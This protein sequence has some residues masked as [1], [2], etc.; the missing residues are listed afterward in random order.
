MTSESAHERSLRSQPPRIQ[1]GDGLTALHW[2]DREAY[3]VVAVSESR[4]T[5]KVQ[6]DKAIRTDDRGRSQHQTYRYEPQPDAKIISL[7]WS[8][9]QHCYL[10]RGLQFV[11]GRDAYRDPSF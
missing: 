11:P 8:T 1:V 9:K 10:Y 6:P 2:S 7:R 3:T 4:N 5:V